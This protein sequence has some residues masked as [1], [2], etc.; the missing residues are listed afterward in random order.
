VVVDL[1]VA[2]LVAVIVDLMLENPM[3]LGIC[4]LG[5]GSRFVWADVVVRG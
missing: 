2:S 3:A 5:S 4:L 1:K